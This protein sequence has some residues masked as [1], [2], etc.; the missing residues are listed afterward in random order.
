MGDVILHARQTSI[1]ISL[2]RDDAGKKM[3]SSH[4]T[5]PMLRAISIKAIQAAKPLNDL[6]R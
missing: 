6:L 5:D 2:G 3:A 1:D 4:K